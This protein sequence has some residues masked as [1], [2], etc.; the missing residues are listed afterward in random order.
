M[1]LFRRPD[2]K[3]AQGVPATRRIMPYLMRG[4]N[5]SLVYFEQ[6]L[7]LDKT[8]PFLERWNA[9]HDRRITVFHVFLHAFVQ[10]MKERPR[11]NRFVSGGR[12]YDRD[13]IWVSFSAK[14]ALNDDSPIIVLKRRFDDVADLAD[15]V[16]RVHGDVDQ[17]RGPGKSTVDKE[18]GLVLAMPGPVVRFLMWLMRSLDAWNLLPGALIRSDP[19]YASVFIANLGSVRLEAPYHHLYE[20][21]NIPIFAAIG[22]VKTVPGL[23]P[24][25][26][27]VVPRTVCDVHYSFD[28]RV[29]DGLYCASSLE[30][31]KAM[32]EDPGATFTSS[33]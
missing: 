20:W 15:T 9:T 1:P 5:E 25:G 10:M 14:K 7:D 21:G 4:R 3:V 28:E 23:A 19:M 8:L 33:S 27:S 30:R 26:A 22:K 17:G 12:L 13:G 29:E 18:L 11:V 31:L 32:V 2:G 24:D 6:R 16:A